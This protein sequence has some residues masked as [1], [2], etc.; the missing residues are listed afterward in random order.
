MRYAE[1]VVNELRRTLAPLANTD[2]AKGARAYMKD[3]APFI[4]VRA[5]E[6]RATAKALF[7]TLDRPDSHT[8]GETAHV[9]YA[10]KEREFAY[11]ANDM[12]AFFIKCAD[13]DFLEQH[14]QELL[15]TKSWWDT[16]DGLGSSAICPL[17]LA[18]PN[19]RLINT[20]NSSDN[21]WLVRAAI[22]HQ[23]GRRSETDVEYVLKICARHS[24]S[25]EFFITKAVGWA[26]RDIAA[27]N[28]PAVRRYLHEHP[29]LN[30]VTTREAERGLN[31]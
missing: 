2:V 14:V 3:V 24:N 16:V 7:K 15:I 1:F 21:M 6:R 5:P 23:R 4:G 28:K 31:R 18:F 19:K 20:W 8:L 26:L 12:I 27:F 9:L 25:R 22:Q 17:T 29:E 11:C 13:Q 10:Q 30:R